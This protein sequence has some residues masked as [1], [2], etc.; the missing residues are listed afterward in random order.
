MTSRACRTAGYQTADLPEKDRS[1]WQLLGPGAILVGLAIGSGE[2]IMWPRMTAK[3]G[4]SMTWAAIVGV[5]L[6]LWV[7]FEIGR[8]TIATGESVYSGFSRIA[9]FFGP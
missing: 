1:F 7:N 8:Y 6:Q 5:F 9:R 2:L 4:P 3:F